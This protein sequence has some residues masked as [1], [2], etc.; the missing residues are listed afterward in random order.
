MNKNLFV[1]AFNHKT[2]AARN[3]SLLIDFSSNLEFFVHAG[4]PRVLFFLTRRSLC[5]IW[6]THLLGPNATSTHSTCWGFFFV[7]LFIYLLFLHVWFCLFISVVWC[8]VP[9]VILMTFYFNFEVDFCGI[10]VDAQWTIGRWLNRK[11]RKWHV[12]FVFRLLWHWSLPW[13]IAQDSEVWFWGVEILVDQSN[14]TSKLIQYHFVWIFV[15]HIGWILDWEPVST[16]WMPVA[17]AKYND[18]PVAPTIDVWGYFQSLSLLEM[19][20]T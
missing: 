1:F 11:R 8:I 4:I 15:R 19:H 20:N 7:Y 17:T 2:C 9:G 14:T 12:Y 13:S 18:L 6:L 10:F 5:G 16:R 3:T